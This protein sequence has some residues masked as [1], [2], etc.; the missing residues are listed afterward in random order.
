MRDLIK[1]LREFEQL[2]ETTLKR[3]QDTSVH[4]IEAARQKAIR[5]IEKE[6]LKLGEKQK[7]QIAKI[8]DKALADAK[9]IHSDYK[10]KENELEKVYKK[11]LGNV[12]NKIFSE[13]LDK[14][15]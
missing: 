8:K 6:K 13:I 2:K 14:N 4:G 9:K 3:T 7:T 5:M 1:D 12:I 10:K 11:N 15:V